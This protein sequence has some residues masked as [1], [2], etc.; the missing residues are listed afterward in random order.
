MRHLSFNFQKL[1]SY[2]PECTLTQSLHFSLQISHKIH[3]FTL[4]ISLQNNF[5]VRLWNHPRTNLSLSVSFFW[6]LLKIN[7]YIYLYIMLFPGTI[8]TSMN[9]QVTVLILLLTSHEL[10]TEID[11][12]HYGTFIKLAGDFE[13]NWT[14][15]L[16][17][18]SLYNF[19]ESTI[20]HMAAETCNLCAS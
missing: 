12:L 4:L 11:M 5:Q 14:Q 10:T 13:K 6:Y 17:A 8:T 20:S 18:C 7:I 2:F 3:R 15:N 1:K 19:K 16:Q 9:L